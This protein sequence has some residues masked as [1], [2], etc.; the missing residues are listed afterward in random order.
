MLLDYEYSV[1]V[2]EILRA[3]NSV[4]IMQ[5]KERIEEGMG[6]SIARKE[7]ARKE[8]QGKR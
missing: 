1:F 4:N 7:N 8:T 6:R 3:G 2:P 5:I